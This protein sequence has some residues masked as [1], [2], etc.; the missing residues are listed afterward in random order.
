MKI[1]K[2]AIKS[3]EIIDNLVTL[4]QYYMGGTPEFRRIVKEDVQYL[5]D[6]LIEISEEHKLHN[7]RFASKLKSLW[8]AEMKEKDKV[9]KG[10][11][12]EIKESYDSGI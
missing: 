1:P 5:E 2:R 10:L 11:E 7:I 4:L 9:I 8:K 6:Y 12:K 3:Q